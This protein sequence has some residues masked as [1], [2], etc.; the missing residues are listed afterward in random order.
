VERESPNSLPMVRMDGQHLPACRRGRV[1]SRRRRGEAARKHKLEI[2]VNRPHCSNLTKDTNCVLQKQ[3]KHGKIMLLIQNGLP[4]V[5]FHNK[6]H[7]NIIWDDGAYVFTLATN[8]DV[9]GA[10]LTKVAE[11]VKPLENQ[12]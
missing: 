5:Y 8:G 6:G 10:D 4:G 12:P 11:S 1:C 3:I 7:D 9:S 2:Y